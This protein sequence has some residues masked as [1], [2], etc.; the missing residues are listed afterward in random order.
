M[1]FPSIKYFSEFKKDGSSPNLGGNLTIS[2]RKN[3]LV[4]LI[5]K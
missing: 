5:E 4:V 2:I 1:L 3:L